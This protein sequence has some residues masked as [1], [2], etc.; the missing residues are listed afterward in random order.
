MNDVTKLLEKLEILLKTHDVYYTYSD[1]HKVWTKG[2]RERDS[3]N[4]YYALLKEAGHL[5]AADE[6]IKKYWY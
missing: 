2:T 5:E 4:L 3:I 6:L 1:D